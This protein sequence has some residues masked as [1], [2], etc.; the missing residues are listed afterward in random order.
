MLRVCRWLARVWRASQRVALIGDDPELPVG[1]V[2]R[3]GLVS[4]L[5]TTT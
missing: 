5:R 1:V 3:F 4:A 2:C